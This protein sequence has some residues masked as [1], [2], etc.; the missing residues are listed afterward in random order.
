MNMESR[1]KKAVEK[2]YAT[3][4]A[5]G[6]VENAF[7]VLSENYIDHDIP[8][9]NGIGGREDLKN[10]VIAVRSAFPDIKPTL[11]E[12][13]EENNWV[14]VRVEASGHHT[15]SSFMGIPPSGKSIR[16]KEV[17]LFK[18]NNNTI[19]EHKGVFDLMSIIHQLNI[20]N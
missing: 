12:M 14:C 18:C 8:G 19:V 3:L 2:L 16:W 20:M 9:F 10:A 13:V 17:H 6:D 11:Y 5:E 4:M 15:G 1:N 7:T